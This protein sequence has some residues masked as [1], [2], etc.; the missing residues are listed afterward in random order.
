MPTRRLPQTSPSRFI[1]IEA[2][3]ERKD[4]LPAPP[5]IPYSGGT[6]T[7][8]DAFYVPYKTKMDAVDAALIV[9]GASTALVKST[10]R[11]AE[12]LILHFYAALQNAVARDLFVGSIRPGYGLDIND[13]TLPT[14]KSEADINFWGSKINTG[15]T[16]R[17]AGGGAPV[18][19]PSLAQVNTAA[20]NFKNA[21]LQQ[22]NAKDLYDIAQEE[23]ELLD[24]EADKLI[25]K[26][27]NE[28]EAA[29]DE[30]NKP[31]MRRKCREWGVVYVPIP[32]ETPTPEDFSIIGTVTDSV[33]GLPIG[34][35]TV[36]T[37]SPVVI[38]LTDSDG[39]Y[40]VP[41]LNAGSY[42]M[43]VHKEGYTEQDLSPVVVTAGA[44]TTVNFQLVTAPALTNVVLEADLGSLNIAELITAGFTFTPSSTV[45]VEISGNECVLSASDVPGPVLGPNSFHNYPGNPQTKTK[46]AFDALVGASPTHNRLKIQCVG[47]LPAHYKIT[48]NNVIVP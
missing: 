31:S 18:T 24:P 39:K 12:L 23:L 38:V 7:R 19:F 11:Q 42:S 46:D 3:K 17:V 35:A 30:G 44:I 32:G 47:P 48:F 8:M 25:L 21:N 28:T 20:T 34:G 2:G 10:R 45:H 27:W 22:S 26:M 1:A 33:S 13:A 41:F 37:T 5:I 43:N 4:M 15:E 14:I 6:I 16:A 40:Y 36:T 29:F 9:Q